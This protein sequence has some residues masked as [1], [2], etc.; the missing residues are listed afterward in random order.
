MEF[1]SAELATEFASQDAAQAAAATK[2]RR[3]ITIHQATGDALIHASSSSAAVMF[4]TPQTI[5]ASQAVLTA[6]A[7][8]L[9][10]Y[11]T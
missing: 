4:G 9:R 5:R 3:D 1:Q 8:H 6:A 7:A 10:M 11:A 2:Q